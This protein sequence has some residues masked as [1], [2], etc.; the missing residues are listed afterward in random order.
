MFEVEEGG[1]LPQTTLD[2]F[3]SDDLTGPFDEKEKNAKGL[4][5]KPETN[6]TLAQLAGS[7]VQFKGVEANFGWRGCPS[8][9]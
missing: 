7:R 1:V 5:L 3:T 9:P 8:M 4:R 2:F 6:S